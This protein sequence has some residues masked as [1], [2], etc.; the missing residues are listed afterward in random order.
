MR[1]RLEVPKAPATETAMPDAGIKGTMFGNKVLL[2]VKD[3]EVLCRDF[4]KGQCKEKGK[5][6]AKGAR[7]C[8]VV[9][10]QTGDQACGMPNHGASQHQKP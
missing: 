2:T 5:I 6:C 9:V 10:K 1:A 7:K 8:G 4:Q 3:G